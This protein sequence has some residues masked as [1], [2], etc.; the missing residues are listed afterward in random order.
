MSRNKTTLQAPGDLTEFP[1]LEIT[2][3]TPW[4]RVHSAEV[5][6][7]FFSCFPGRF[8]LFAPRGTLNLASDSYTA[9]REFLGPT[10]VGAR[11]IPESFV[12]EKV[13]TSLRVH[14]CQVADFSAESAPAF[15]VE[16]ET[17]HSA[18]SVAK[19]LPGIR[20]VRTPSASLLKVES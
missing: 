3:S 13:I 12:A 8:N 1:V 7:Q 19:T 14:A 10:L 6:P 16:V 18:L 2:K 11:L 5:G 20:V 15:G 4:S 9:L 17:T